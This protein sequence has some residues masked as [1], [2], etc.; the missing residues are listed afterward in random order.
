M[1]KGFLMLAHL[2]VCSSLIAGCSSNAGKTASQSQE[3]AAPASETKMEE[4]VKTDAPTEAPKEKVK[5]TIAARGGSHVDAMSLVKEEFEKEHNA[6][7]EILG[8]ES[9]D[10]KQK[11]SL[12]SKNKEGAYDLIMIDD[13]WMPEF[14]QA[15][16]LED[17]TKL[18]IE[19]DA[20]F[21][22][23]SLDIGKVPYAE[24]DLY[25]LPFS[26][27][28]QFLFYNKEILDKNN[29]TIPQSWEELYDIADNV[30]KGGQGLGYVIRGEQ[31][32]PIVSDF[33]PILWACGGKVFDENWK[34]AVNTPEAKK[35]L[36]MYLK[37]AKAG[38]NYN[39][40][41]IVT[42]VSEGKAAMSLGW[43]SWYISGEK[44]AA[45]YC[46]IPTKFEKSGSAH[47]TGMIGNWMM[48]IAANSKNKELAAEFLK[49][50]TSSSVQKQMVPAGGVPT[51]VS[52]CTDEALAKQY[53]Y[54][55]TLLEATKNSVVRPRT[56][57]WSQVEEA[58]GAELSSA[59]AET[60]TIDQALNDANEAINQIMK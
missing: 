27:N 50:I 60:K 49:Y 10:L 3:S 18:G 15:N 11:V 7:I 55:P 13:P 31:G 17:L 25:A 4:A 21:I 58:F 59:V 9:A 30:Q 40:A 26:G 47:A 23:Q 39:K 34:A 42:A 28:V 52:V 51:R 48:G 44:A 19:E 57:K 5:L 53:Q 33:L 1:K 41:D 16:T 22:K 46:P 37:L 20:D 2:I 54:L 14:T 32:N 29:L 24:G 12:D 43:P 38:A 36:E 35:A 45:Q 8:L 56:E 6:E